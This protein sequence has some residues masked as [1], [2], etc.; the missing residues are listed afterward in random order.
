MHEFIVSIFIWALFDGVFFTLFI[1][2][3]LGWLGCDPG[4]TYR[5]IPYIPRSGEVTVPLRGIY[6]IIRYIGPLRAEAETSASFHPS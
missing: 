3:L 5:K 2:S 1:Y 6:G 4:D